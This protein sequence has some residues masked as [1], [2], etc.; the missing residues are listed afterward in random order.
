MFVTC[1]ILPF[2]EKGKDLNMEENLKDKKSV[3]DSEKEEND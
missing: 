3:K 1:I 2:V